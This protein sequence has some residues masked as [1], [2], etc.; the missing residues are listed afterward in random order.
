MTRLPASICPLFSLLATFSLLSLTSRAAGP[1]LPLAGQLG[2]PVQLTAVPDAEGQFYKTQTT[3]DGH[4]Y[5]TPNECFFPVLGLQA[6]G[7]GNAALA[8]ELNGNKSFTTVESW[9]PGKSA[10]WGIL[11]A[12]PGK[13]ELEVWMS[14]AGRG[15]HFSLSIDDTPQSFDVP[16]SETSAAAYRATFDLPQAGFHQ[17][18]LTCDKSA[19]KPALH[20]I[21]VSGDAA[22]GGA[23]LRQRW[24]PSAAHARFSSSKQT[25]NIQLWIMEQDAQPGTLD[26]YSPLTT[27]FGYYGAS[28]KADGRVNTSFNF[29]LWSFARGKDEPPIDQLSHL[30]AIGNGDAKFSGFRH[31][32]TGVKVRGWQPLEGHQSQRQVFALR[33]EPGT[34]YSTYYSYYYLADEDRWQLYAVGNKFNDNRAPKSLWVGS[35]VEVPGAA[36]RQRTGIYPRTMRYRG[37]IENTDGQWFALDQMRYGDVDRET[38]L[39]GT[40]RGVNDEGWFYLSTGGWTFHE[41]AD[42]QQVDNPQARQPA[43]LPYLT[44][45]HLATLH[46]TP[47]DIRTL[48][49]TREAGQLVGKFTIRHP[50]P[51]AT[52]QVFWGTTEG[53]T[54]ADRWQHNQQLPAPTEGTNEFRLPNVPTDQ[55]IYLRLLLCDSEGQYW[56]PTT[57]VVEPTP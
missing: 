15:G 24:R 53:L 45:Q 36:S 7:D 40:Q 6:K 18:R 49:V 22:E 27:P 44:R 47:S 1:A 46:T 21:V 39:T 10:E 52:A 35:F 14:A 43:K 12:K 32:G 29:S 41:P 56:T 42:E 55:T 9:A 48:Q 50:S 11:L 37:W 3:V 16:T 28:W 26:F 30:L 23:V 2:Q 20:S 33:I 51:P 57:T 4:L 31:E 34:P 8:D 54:F 25:G 13:V 17:V 38:R 5:L 19:G